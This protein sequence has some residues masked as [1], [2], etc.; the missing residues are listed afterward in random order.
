MRDRRLRYTLHLLIWCVLYFLPYL[1]FH[2]HT[3]NI[4]TMF[5]HPGDFVHLASSLLLIG[6]TYFNFFVL[7]PGLYFKRSYVVYLLIVFAGFLVVVWLPGACMNM[8]PGVEGG[9][10]ALAGE[11]QQP[12]FFGKNYNIILFLLSVFIAMSIQTRLRLLSIERERLNAE[13]SFLKAQINPHFLFNSLNSIYSL[14]IQRSDRTADA[15]V[16]LSSLMRYIMRD[17]KADR[18]ELQKELDYILNY[19]DL[20]KTRLGDTVDIQISINGDP[21]GYSIVPLVLM[22]FVENAFKHGVNPDENSR[23]KIDFKIGEGVLAFY[24]VNNKVQSVPSEEYSGIGIENTEQ[25]LEH[26]YPGRHTL[27]IIDAK[28]TFTVNLSLEL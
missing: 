16:Q 15:V 21:N 25:R 6:F 22:S 12:F 7:I 4:Y 19:V 24:I 3:T 23:I 10:P 20:Q 28:D 26:L 17:A 13:L 27:K 2:E 11:N 18:V 14:A 5:S 9:P 8:V 1:V